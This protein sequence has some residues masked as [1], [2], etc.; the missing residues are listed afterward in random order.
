MTRRWGEVEKGTTG[1][2]PRRS[3]LI[4]SGSTRAPGTVPSAHLPD[5]IAPGHLQHGQPR[6][7]TL[8]MNDGST[9][10]E[11][12]HPMGCQPKAR[13]FP[14]TADQD[15]AMERGHQGPAPPAAPLGAWSEPPAARRP[16]ASGELR[17]SEQPLPAPLGDI[18]PIIAPPRPAFG[19]PSGWSCLWRRRAR[20]GRA[21]PT[22]VPSPSVSPALP[23]GLACVSWSQGRHA[24]RNPGHAA[25]QHPA[26]PRTAPPASSPRTRD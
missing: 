2:S 7:R 4:G 11:A 12:L 6:D 16:C 23:S 22:P 13:Q 3:R 10:S 18:G 24:I 14:K 1:Q 9:N 17:S 8:A 26:P 5:P 19:P 21:S 25:S 20:C 15:L